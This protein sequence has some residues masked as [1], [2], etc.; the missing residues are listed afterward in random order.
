MKRYEEEVGEYPIV[1]D[2]II[3]TLETMRVFEIERYRGGF[4]IEEGCD[5]NFRAFLSIDEMKKL[6]QEI[7]DR[8]ENYEQYLIANQASVNQVN[9]NEDQSL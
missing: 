7:L 8:A 3:D 4:Y 1:N 6:G 5:G 9:E 2:S